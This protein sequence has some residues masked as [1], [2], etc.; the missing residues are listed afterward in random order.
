MI[1]NNRITKKY[2]G[3]KS[4]NCGGRC[5]IKNKETLEILRYY[6]PFCPRPTEIIND[7][8]LRVLEP[9]DT[10]S[11]H[12][13]TT[14]NR[15]YD[16]FETRYGEYVYKHITHM[17]QGTAFKSILYANIVVWGIPA[18][19]IFMSLFVFGLYIFLNSLILESN[20]EDFNK[21][22]IKYENIKKMKQ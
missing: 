1:H 18:G 16:Y 3:S 12:M 4:Y 6:I 22:K 5:L 2:S 11:Q 21:N 17:Y 14:K 7:N 9:S 10:D 19:N 8:F 13:N 15:L 20:C